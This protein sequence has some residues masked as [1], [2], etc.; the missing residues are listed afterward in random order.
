MV[1]QHPNIEFRFNH[2]RYGVILIFRIFTLDESP[3]RFQV[4][5]CAHSSSESKTSIYRYCT[6]L[7]LC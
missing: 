2:Y 6:F 3:N 7:L 1:N 4:Q 5:F